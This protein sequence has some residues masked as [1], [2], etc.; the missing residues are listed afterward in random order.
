LSADNGT[1]IIRGEAAWFFCHSE[2]GLVRPG[3]RLLGSVS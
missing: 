3:V 2:K 1:A